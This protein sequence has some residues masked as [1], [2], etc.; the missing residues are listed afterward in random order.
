M[1]LQDILKLEDE[2]DMTLRVP[3]EQKWT[4]VAFPLVRQLAKYGPE[5]PKCQYSARVLKAFE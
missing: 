5:D 2:A 1:V 4:E 3:K